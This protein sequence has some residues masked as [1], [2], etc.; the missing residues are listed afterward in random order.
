MAR[1]NG[2]GEAAGVQAIESLD[3]T[4]P[5]TFAA[6]LDYLWSLR[7]QGSV[8]L[9]FAG[10]IPRAVELIERTHIPLDTLSLPK[11]A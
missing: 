8:T 7:F 2:N 3:L 4:I 9:H 11:G 10:G 5:P 1:G 6:L